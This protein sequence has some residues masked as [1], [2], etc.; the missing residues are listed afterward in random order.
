MCEVSQK[1]E[2]AIE[3]PRLGNIGDRPGQ[4]TLGPTDDAKQPAVGGSWQPISEDQP[5]KDL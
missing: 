2:D 3:D 5:L 1:T 4:A